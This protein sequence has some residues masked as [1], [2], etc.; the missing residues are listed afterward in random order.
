MRRPTDSDFVVLIDGY[1]FTRH[2][3][4]FEAIREVESLAAKGIPAFFMGYM[5]YRIERGMKR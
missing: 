3:C 4:A 5:D 2:G 1:V